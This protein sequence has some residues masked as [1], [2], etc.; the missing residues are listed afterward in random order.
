MQNLAWAE[1]SET[2]DKAFESAAR[3]T[4]TAEDEIEWRSEAQ[5]GFLNSRG[6]TNDRTFNGRV[7]I[8][9]ET[10]RWRNDSRAHFLHTRSDG[11]VTQ[12]A[13]TASHQTDYQWTQQFY[14]LL[15]TGL[16]SDRFATFRYEYDLVGGLGYRVIRDVRQEWDLEAGLGGQYTERTGPPRETG[17]SPLGRLVS[18]YRQELGENL[19][20]QQT[21]AYNF[22]QEVEDLRLYNSLAV[23]ANKHLAVSLSY[24]WRRSVDQQN[25]VSSY[26]QITTLNL[27]YSWEP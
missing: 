4:A 21:L 15:F 24:E 7:R 16:Q 19:E 17:F 25:L 23:K 1:E 27:I 14:S 22:S 13:F 26:D 5:V 6:K 8:R 3:E 12:E 11:K 2:L 10:P 20:F 18:K 9:A